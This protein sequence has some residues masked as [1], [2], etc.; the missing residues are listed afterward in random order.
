MTEQVEL[1]ALDLA[2]LL[3]SRVCHDIISPVG[4]IINGLEVLDEDNSE[5]MRDFAFGLIRR[6]AGQASAKLQF[7]RLAFGAA[8]LGRCRD[9]PRRRREGGDRL[10]AGR[11]GG[12]RLGGAARPDAQE[13]GQAAA[14]PDAACQCGRAARGQIKVSV[15]VGR[16][17]RASCCGPRGRAPGC[18]RL[19]RSSCRARSVTRRSMRSSSR[20][21]TPVRW[22]GPAASTIGARL[23]GEDVV[24]ER[25]RRALPPEAVAGRGAGGRSSYVNQARLVW[26]RGLARRRRILRGAMSIVWSSMIP[27]S[28][29][30]WRGVSWKISISRSPRPRTAARR[31]TPVAVRC[32]T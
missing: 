12:F 5:E 18:R 13:P 4:A 32:P 3:C 31:S 7:A 27:A 19:S 10:H 15:E 17:R 9:R 28:S 25:C 2:A 14:Q 24:I 29:G 11:E 8:G 26:P 22:R 20:P 1:E 30:R 21:T 6:S 16:R 23:D